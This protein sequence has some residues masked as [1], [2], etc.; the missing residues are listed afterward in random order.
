MLIIIENS[1]KKMV[2]SLFNFNKRC[3]YLL[4]NLFVIVKKYIKFIE[5]FI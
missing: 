5:K 1:F 3:G 2:C 4:R